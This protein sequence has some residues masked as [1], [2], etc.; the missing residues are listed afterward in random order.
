MTNITFEEFEKKDVRGMMF[1]RD[2]VSFLI[3]PLIKSGMKLLSKWRFYEGR[4]QKASI[5]G[6]AANSY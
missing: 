3:S 4:N 1:E 2:V 6:G 5:G